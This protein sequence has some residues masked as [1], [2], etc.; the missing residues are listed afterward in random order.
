MKNDTDILLSTG[1]AMPALGLGTWKSPP[2]KAG[3]AVEHALTKCGY[4]H[5]DCAAIYRNEKEIGA[6]FKKIFED[7]KIKRED[8]F[9]TSK[10]WNS[11]HTRENVRNAC[12]Q[13]L[14]DLNLKYL[15]LYL[16][17]W[18]I[19]I[20]PNEH[21]KN[22]LTGRWTEEL[23]K[24]G[25]LITDKISIRETWEAMEEVGLTQS[26]MEKIPELVAKAGF[27]PKVKK[28]VIARRKATKQSNKI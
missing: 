28:I 16:M 8:I 11:E 18:G 14:A 23:D 3:Q 27:T 21:P 26:S 9:I 1:A 20:P 22:N 2:E 10:L 7:G 25:F 4:R 12:E 6:V 19:A 13:T 24:N 17:H 15:D 5:I